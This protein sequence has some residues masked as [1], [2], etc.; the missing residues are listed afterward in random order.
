MRRIKQ[1]LTTKGE[2]W[3]AAWTKCT[4]GKLM[5]LTRFPCVQ[6]LAY[7][8]VKKCQIMVKLISDD[9]AVNF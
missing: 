1:A 4:H 6:D 7:V 3:L 8:Y 2:H 5:A 9:N